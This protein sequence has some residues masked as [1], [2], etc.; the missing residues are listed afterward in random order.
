MPVAR[1][2]MPDGR[3]GRF[4]V[5][6][7]TTPEQAQALI[8]QSLG[9]QT[10][11]PEAPAEQAAPE[12][13]MWQRAKPYVMPTAE[14]IGM[15]GGAI[16]GAVPGTLA[17]PGP[18]TVGGGVLGAGLGYAGVK[19]LER[20]AD[21][22]FGE[23]APSTPM[24]M[25]GDV[26]QNVATGGAFELGGQALF[27]LPAAVRAKWANIIRAR[28]AKMGEEIAGARLP[29]IKTA[30]Q[31]SVPGETAG[32][33][34]AGAGI[35]A[36]PF[37]AAERYAAKQNSIPFTDVRLAQEE[38]RRAGLASVT[39]DRA[40]A[41]AARTAASKPLYQQADASLAPA[42]DGAMDSL[43][44]PLLARPA[45]RSAVRAAEETA[46]NKGVM[47]YDQHG[48][49]TGQGAHLIKV[50]LDDAAGA[51]ARTT[52]AQG[53]Q[54]G[55]RT[56]KDEFLTWLKPHIPSYDAGRAA[57]AANSPKVNQSAILTDIQ[58][59][60]KHP[61]SVGERVGPMLNAVSTGASRLLKRSGV[62]RYQDGNIANALTTP[63]MGQVNKVVN[64]LTRDAV[65]K[66]Q[67]QQGGEQF[68]TIMRKYG[69]EVQLPNPL[70]AKITIANRVLSTMQGRLNEKALRELGDAMLSG[71]STLEILNK[72]PAHQRSALLKAL[73]NTQGGQGAVVNALTGSGGDYA[74]P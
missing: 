13:T 50:E 10:P 47:M 15:A 9:E 28:A 31:N 19:E 73:Q 71:K 70:S 59:V 48:N 46:A 33:A 36:P 42:L 56:A 64:E 23:R 37:Q 49:L 68:N 74:S 40:A 35:N 17:A 18:G 63:Q 27:A 44:Q 53:A 61:A 38:A 58:N 24:Q 29:E 32:Q 67:A 26:A 57:F 7:G 5:P 62:Q 11:E 43:G 72:V 55:I 2:Q 30:L 39:P 3:I 12:Q 8:Q 34:V 20:L 25:A 52:A 16:L 41:E 4:E 22:Q 51:V 69:Q 60:L 1:F 6:D 45:I 21:Q 14:A 65:M 54:S 66:Q